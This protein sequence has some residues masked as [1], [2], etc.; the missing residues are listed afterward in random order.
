VEI[1]N[2]RLIAA[3]GLAFGLLLMS[4]SKETSTEST[5]PVDPADP[6]IGLTET[7]VTASS[8]TFGIN[9]FKELV[10]YKP[11]QNVFISPLSVAAA[12]TMTYNGAGGNTEEEMK[13][14]L[15]YSGLSDQEIN[16]S[17]RDLVFYLTQ[18]DSSVSVEIANSIWY[19]MSFA[20]KEEFLN[21]NRQYF[22]AEVAGLDFNDETSAD[23]INDWVDES[24]HGK[25]D[26]IVKKP[27]PPEMVMYLINAVYFKGTW[28]YQFHDSLTTDGEF[29][30]PDGTKK[31][32]RLMF[33][34][35]EMSYFEDSAVQMVDLPYGDEKFSMTVILPRPG[36]DI[37]TFVGQ[38][39][40]EALDSRLGAL[41]STEGTLYLPRFT[42]EYEERLN[43]VLQAMGIEDAFTH[44]ADF[45]GMRDAKDVYISL[46]KHKSLLEVNEEGT[47]A[48]AVTVVGVG[49]TSVGPEPFAMM[50]DR[51]FVLMIRERE[52][53]VVLFIGMI[54]NPGA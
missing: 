16:E 26:N 22:A 52:S 51:P 49:V 32:V 1:M 2:R 41:S 27:I 24:T 54:A 13:Q 47:V 40:E 7:R 17:F 20:F 53:G 44:S 33:Q 50:V 30:L 38:L 48:A 36:T 42:V 9:L 8:N 45:S 11:D 10:A 19:R 46:V 21:L 5:D 31:P 43:D 23:V 4:C 18:L 3:L 35:A 6:K 12:L 14:T 28:T 37:N 29:N 39:D 34:G 15:G 25:I